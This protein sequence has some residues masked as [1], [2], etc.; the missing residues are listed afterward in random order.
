M[1]FDELIAMGGASGGSKRHWTGPLDEYLLD[2]SLTEE[3]TST[4]YC[5]KGKLEKF[6]ILFSAQVD[7]RDNAKRPRTHHNIINDED[8]DPLPNESVVVD[9]FASYHGKNRPRRKQVEPLNNARIKDGPLDYMKILN[10]TKVKI[11][12]KDL[13]QISPA[14]RKHWKHDMS[15]VNDKRSR[16]KRWQAEFSEVAL[17]LPIILIMTI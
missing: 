16:K 12:L 11:S 13:A 1:S 15:R 6:K 4:T 3:L 17:K 14:A 9:E 8:I 7:E 2:E 10:R 5:K